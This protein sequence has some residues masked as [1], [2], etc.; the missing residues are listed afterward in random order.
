MMHTNTFQ[1][2]AEDD[3]LQWCC[4]ALTEEQV[5]QCEEEA[6]QIAGV[7]LNEDVAAELLVRT[8]ALIV[9]R[10]LRAERAGG[11]R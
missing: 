2:T 1:T 3:A 5:D 9:I 11:V 8:L 4:L 10:N 6:L 7:E